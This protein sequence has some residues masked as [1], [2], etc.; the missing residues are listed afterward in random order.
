ML[1]DQI[2]ERKEPRVTLRMEMSLVATG[3]HG[4]GAGFEQ[5]M[6]S[7]ILTMSGGKCPLH[8]QGV[9]SSRQLDVQVWRSGVLWRE[10]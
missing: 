1:T 2:V 3:K 8:V 4:G 9:M 10:V 6:R 7:S 5:H